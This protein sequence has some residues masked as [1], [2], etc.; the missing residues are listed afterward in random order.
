[1]CRGSRGRMGD[2]GV[3]AKLLERCDETGRVAGHLAGA[4]IG[5]GFASTADGG[6]HDLGEQ[7]S[8]DEQREP[9]E[10]ERVVAVGAV[11]IAWHAAAV[12]PHQANG[13]IGEDGDT[14]HQRD[15][16]G[17]YQDVVVADVGEF[18]R[19]HTFELDPVQLLEQTGGDRDGSVPRVAS[20]GE[21][22]RCRIVDDVDA[23]LGQATGDA[24]PL[25]EVVQPLEL[26]G[27]G[28]TCPTDGEGDGVGLPVRGEGDDTRND[29]RDDGSDQP[30]TEQH[31]HRSTHQNQQADEADDEGC[32]LAAIGADEFEHQTRQGNGRTALIAGTIGR[33]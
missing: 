8:D 15:S 27:V 5:E 26:V 31:P 11:A 32:T 18:V 6:L 12:P 3:V 13:G 2:G 1:M 16:K 23:R 28:R 21:G 9:E 4:H 7:W 22:V 14:T 33:Q 10:S 20:G 29:Q 25:D 17:G 19:H 30:V 24:Q